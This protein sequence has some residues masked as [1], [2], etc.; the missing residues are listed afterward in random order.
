MPD[1][2]VTVATFSVPFEADLARNRL[3][4]EDVRAYL[5]DEDTVGLWN[6]GSALGTIKLL[7]AESD[8]PRA[9]AILEAHQATDAELPEG[10]RLDGEEGIQTG[11]TCR[12]C[13]KDMD[14]AAAVCRSCGTPVPERDALRGRCLRRRSTTS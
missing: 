2:L 4:A 7:V 13:G 6:L 11:L 10:A 8:V 12:R 5:G 9:Q 14:P 1:K 3:E